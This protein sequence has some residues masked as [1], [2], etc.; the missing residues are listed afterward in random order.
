M[1]TL[2]RW[3]ELYLAAN[4]RTAFGQR[5]VRDPEYPCAEFLPGEPSGQCMSDGHYLCNECTWSVPLC[6]TCGESWRL[7]ECD[8]D[9][10]S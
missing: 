6:A 4:G 2:D 10:A 7:C 8:P 1:S 5:G 3:N 9:G